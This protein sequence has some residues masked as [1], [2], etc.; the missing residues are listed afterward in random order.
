MSPYSQPAMTPRLLLF[1][2]D[3]TLLLSHGQAGKLFRE[4]LREVY[5]VEARVQGY[6]FA[7]KTDPQIVFELM[8]IVGL[9]RKAVAE[10][11][12]RMRQLYLDRLENRLE[13]GQM[14]LLPGVLELLHRLDARTGL[15]V[16]LLTGNWEP[17]A[18]TKLARFDLNR[19]FAFGGF[20]EDG[21][22]RADLV[23]AALRRARERTGHSFSPSETLII[24]DTIHDVACAKAHAVP[25]LAVATGSTTA[26]RLAAA[27][28]DWVAP[29]LLD[30]ARL[31]PHLAD[32][33]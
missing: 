16:G 12:A 7:G 21:P 18:R 6:D 1:D 22:L 30:A 17:G 2:I 23:P 15:T 27:G 9:E 25:V 19:F 29:T 14:W 3:G 13:R 33:G 20:G 28:A 11:L 31:L 5:G 26:E 32:L 4:C 8:E 10:S 24:G